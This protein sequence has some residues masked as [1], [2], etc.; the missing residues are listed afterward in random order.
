MYC[1][2]S[3]Q[4]R[5]HLEDSVRTGKSKTKQSRRLEVDSYKGKDLK[6]VHGET[7]TLRE[8]NGETKR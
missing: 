3:V 1:K 7:C 8:G 5:R 6:C 2:E 4:I